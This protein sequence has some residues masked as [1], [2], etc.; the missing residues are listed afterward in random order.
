MEIYQQV[1]EEEGR[2]RRD[3][4]SG[5]IEATYYGDIRRNQGKKDNGRRGRG[6]NRE[7]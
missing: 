5:E 3:Y 6:D 7:R 2:N 1:Q 4:T